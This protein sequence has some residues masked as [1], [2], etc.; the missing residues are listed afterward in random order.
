MSAPSTV[1]LVPGRIWHLRR[2]KRLLL[3]G[4]ILVLLLGF[5]AGGY[6]YI[7]RA[8]EKRLQAAIAEADRLD[9]GWRLE[10]IEARRAVIPDEENSARKIILAVRLMEAHVKPGIWVNQIPLFNEL[11]TLSPEIQVNERQQKVL[12]TE[13]KKLRDALAEARK[14]AD[15]PRG[16]FPITYSPD[17][18][19][20]FAPDIQDSRYVGYLLLMDVLLRLQEKDAAG[21]LRSWKASFNTS[22]AVG[23]DPLIVAQMIRIILR[24][25]ALDQLERML[26]QVELS[27]AQL[28]DIQ[29][30]LEEEKGQPTLLIGARGERAGVHRFMEALKADNARMS[31]ISPPGISRYLGISNSALD[32]L[33]CSVLAGSKDNNHAAMLE[34]HTEF[35]EIAKLPL[36][37]QGPRLEALLASFSNQPYLARG[38]LP[39]M[40]RMSE[41]F[42]RGQAELRSAIAALAV[43]RYRV[44]HQRWPDS[45]G[46]LVPDK[47]V[48]V[49]VDPYDGES[50]RYRRPDHGVVIYSLGPDRQDNDGNVTFRPPLHNRASMSVFGSGTWTSAANRRRF[51]RGLSIHGGAA[52]SRTAMSEPSC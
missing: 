11:Q 10:E 37:Q 19:S 47:L 34:T 16:R 39:A 27:E 41:L 13:L 22:R 15:M 44:K 1:Q 32:E 2:S 51:P 20:T 21:A 25:L 4:G 50:L 30:M 14:V 35:V 45:L 49:P 6:F 24:D 17:A 5:L 42:Q 28:A 43:E 12:Q 33:G 7:S 23:D 18:F 3:I 29:Q 36:E 52:W 38:L 40:R 31:T 48:Q 8:A 26:A 46:I 9:P